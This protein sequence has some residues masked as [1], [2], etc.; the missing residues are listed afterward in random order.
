VHMQLVQVS[1]STHLPHDVDDIHHRHSVQAAPPSPPPHLPHDV[2]DILP[3]RVPVELLHAPV[4]DQRGVQR[5]E[6]I[7][8]GGEQKPG[9]GG[10]TARK[11]QW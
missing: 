8:C 5:A 9:V 3:V 6:V 11:T 4:P 7:A 10:Y 1:W 2:D